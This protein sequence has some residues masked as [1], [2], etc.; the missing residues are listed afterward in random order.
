MTSDELEI[1]QIRIRAD[2]AE[3]LLVWLAG[4]LWA[5]R[6]CAGEPLQSQMLNEMEESLS[7]ARRHHELQTIPGVSSAESDMLTS[8]FLEAFD[9]L[10][11]VVFRHVKTGQ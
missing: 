4:T 5:F 11:E 2:V 1:H 3:Q 7:F 10:S 9:A 8:E 6:K